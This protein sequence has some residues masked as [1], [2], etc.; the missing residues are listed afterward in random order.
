MSRITLVS[1]NIAGGR[2]EF[3]AD[4]L[5]VV[6]GRSRSADITINDK[7]LSRRH[8]EIVRNPNGQFEIRDLESTNLT[9]VNEQD[10]DNRILR[11]G[12][13]LLLGETEIRIE[14]EIAPDDPSERTT[15]EINLLPP[16][17][18]SDNN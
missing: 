10:V 18:P 6:L 16:T 14:I 11:S 7:L 1:P 15:R 17:P 5:P 9:I 3:R 13:I 2:A 12:D 8:S 4:Q